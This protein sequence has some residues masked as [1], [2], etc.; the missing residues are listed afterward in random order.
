[1]QFHMF[2]QRETVAADDRAQRALKSL[3]SYKT[4]WKLHVNLVIP[5]LFYMRVNMW[6]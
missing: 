5:N 1:M 2:L 6:D 3:L 4:V